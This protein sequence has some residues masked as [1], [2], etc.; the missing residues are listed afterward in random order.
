VRMVLT[1]K[2]SSSEGF[3][4]LVASMTDP[5]LLERELMQAR[6]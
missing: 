1:D 5:D 2:E 4:A 6:V 3:T